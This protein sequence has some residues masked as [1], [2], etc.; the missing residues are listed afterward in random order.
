MDL[1]LARTEACAG[2]KATG[3]RKQKGV[4]V[5]NYGVAQSGSFPNQGNNLTTLIPGDLP[6]YLFN[7]ETPTAPQASVAFC[8]GFTPGTGGATVP[9]T[10]EISFASASPTAEVDI[11]GSNTDADADYISLYSSVNQQYDYYSDY[12]GFRFYRAKLVTY[13]S[14]GA[15]TV[16]VKP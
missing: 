5:P 3:D 4:T 12:G 10:F 15:L 7:A 6:F 1:G 14:G 16:L 8:R 2:H 9:L 11:Q 13:S